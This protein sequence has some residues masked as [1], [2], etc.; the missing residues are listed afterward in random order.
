MKNTLLIIIML[1]SMNIYAQNFKSICDTIKIDM[2]KSI[3]TD[4]SLMVDGFRYTVYKYGKNINFIKNRQYINDKL[5][6]TPLFIGMKTKCIFENNIVYSD[7]TTNYYTVFKLSNKNGT[8]YPFSLIKEN[9]CNFRFDGKSGKYTDKSM[10][11]DSVLFD[12]YI[13]DDN[14]YIIYKD[15]NK[16]IQTFFF[17][18]KSD[19]I[20]DYYEVYSDRT[21]RNFYII[22]INEFGIPFKE[23]YK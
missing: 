14:E 20:K 11:I 21:G 16:N 19:M 7:L 6:E 10:Y 9:D 22:K 18:Y 4:D 23:I 5:V 3:R 1:F 13:I 8:I 2:V 17:G 12:I 15:L